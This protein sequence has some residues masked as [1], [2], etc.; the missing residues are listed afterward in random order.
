MSENINT[1]KLSEINNED[2][3]NIKIKKYLP[4][5]IKKIMIENILDVCKIQQNSLIK[6]DY[7]YLKIIKEISMITQYTNIEIPEDIVSAYDYM[8]ENK[9]IEYILD[10]ID[11][12]E[13]LF[14]DDVLK[15]EIRQ[16]EKIDNSIEN[17]LS[18]TLN[19]LT[20]KIPDEKGLVKIIKE[21]PKS[22]NKIKPETLEILK[23]I[24]K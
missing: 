11:R 19:D 24:N 8:K 7:S 10:A 2:F 17:I 5:P 23:N 3:S 13:I 12:D 6:I 16:I 21:I 18:K 4:F 15:S 20:S 14:I 9:I 1:I 22:I